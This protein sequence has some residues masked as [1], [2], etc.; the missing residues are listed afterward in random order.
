VGEAPRIGEINR[1]AVTVWVSGPVTGDRLPHLHD[2]A[3]EL[4]TAACETGVTDLG[5][6]RREWCTH[7]HQQWCKQAFRRLVVF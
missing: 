7:H 1:I 2:G 4:H 6:R 3:A 5:D